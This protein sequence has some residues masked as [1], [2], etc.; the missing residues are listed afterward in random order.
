[1]A[2]SHSNCCSSIN[3]FSFRVEREGLRLATMISVLKI[4]LLF[5]KGSST[6]KSCLQ[7]VEESVIYFQI[8]RNLTFHPREFETSFLILSPKTRRRTR[9]LRVAFVQSFSRGKRI[10]NER[11]LAKE[12]FCLRFEP[13]ES[14]V[15]RKVVQ[16]FLFG[17]LS[18]FTRNYFKRGFRKR[19]RSEIGIN[20][21]E[22]E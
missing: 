15:V 5:W 1:M 3:G 2:A 12:L 16:N 20:V 9:I 22:G 4:A 21:I 17:Q 19:E 14:I 10:R 11:K 7:I 6:R 13:V 18:I 8:K